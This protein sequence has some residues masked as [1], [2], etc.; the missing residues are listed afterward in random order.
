MPLLS[1]GSV[2]AVRRLLPLVAVLVFV[3]TMLYAALTPLLPHFAAELGLSKTGAGAIGGLPGGFTAVRLGARRAVLVGLIAMG[4]ASLGFA[5]ADSFGTLFL[6]RLLQGAG[7]AFTWAGAFAWLLA[8]A[9][10]ER[11]GEL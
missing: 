3:D 5:F 9:P 2:A 8:A 1:V 4:L 7:S 6:A 10:R 11:R